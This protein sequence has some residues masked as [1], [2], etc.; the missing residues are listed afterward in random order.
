MC[1][2]LNDLYFRE[3]KCVA[4]T[5]KGFVKEDDTW[6]SFKNKNCE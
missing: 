1:V 6:W 4:L 3:E 2:F 5:G